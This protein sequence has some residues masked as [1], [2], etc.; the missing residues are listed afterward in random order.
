MATDFFFAVR[1]F[2]RFFFEFF[3]NFWFQYQER[4]RRMHNDST[5][6]EMMASFLSSSKLKSSSPELR[7]FSTTKN[8]KAFEPGLGK[9]IVP[10]LRKLEAERVEHLARIEQQE[11]EI[12]VLKDTIENMNIGCDVMDTIR[13]SRKENEDMKRYLLSIG[14]KWEGHG[15]TRKEEEDTSTTTDMD[16]FIRAMEQLNIVSDRLSVKGNRFV[17]A[18]NVPV[19]VFRDGL[20]LWR[21]PFRSFEEDETAKTF[22]RDCTNGYFPSELRKRWPDGVHFQITDKRDLNYE[23]AKR[24][25]EIS[26]NS[27]SKTMTKLQ[28]LRRP[29]ESRITQDGRVDSVRDRIAASLCVSDKKTGVENDTEEVKE[30]QRQ[31]RRAIM[32]AA[33]ERRMKK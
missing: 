11:K 2:R 33:L 25:D 32:V 24:S 13:D 17:E 14:M 10:R 3:E 18:P 7:R 22:V 26:N 12:E 31:E 1:R 29:P 8:K 19:A 21:G 23:D 6:K 5:E 15:T 28:F 30:R 16:K 9:S 4:S 20:M 27:G